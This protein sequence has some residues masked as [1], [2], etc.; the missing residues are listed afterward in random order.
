MSFV[1]T[2]ALL[3]TAQ[4]PIH[5]VSGDEGQPLPGL[6]ASVAGGADLDLDGVPDFL[7]GSPYHSGTPA[8]RVG[9]YSGVDAAPLFALLDSDHPDQDYF[10]F[11]LATIADVNADG[12]PDFLVGAPQLPGA[13]PEPPGFADVRS[14]ADG[15]LL[16]R[17]DGA[18]ADDG[19][20]HAVAGLDD[21]NADL[22]PDFAVGAVQASDLT[23][24]RGYVRIVSGAD[25]ATLLTLQGSGIGDRFGSAVANAGDLNG[26]GL[27]DILVGAPASGSDK[28]AL[29][30]R[31]AASGA[32]LWKKN[33]S[34]P[35]ELYGYAAAAAGD[36]DADGN[37]DVLV[38][39]PGADRVQVL[40]GSTGA[41]ILELSGA[42]GSFFG[43]VVA[44]VGDVDSDGY[45]D[46][47][48]G[49]RAA[50][51]ETGAAWIF[52][53]R[54]ASIVRSFAGGAA[55]DEYGSSAASAADLDLDGYPDALVGAPQGASA[56]PGY[57]EAR[58]GRPAF[59]GDVTTLPMA[60]GGA[61]N[62]SI[63][64]EPA[65]AGH[66]YLVLG[67]QNGTTPGFAFQ[68]FTVPL[69]ID[70]YFTFTLQFPNE[71]PLY[72]SLGILDSE[73]Q[74]TFTF[75]LPAAKFP[76][77]VGS[78]VHHA[79]GELDPALGALVFVSNP[80]GLTFVP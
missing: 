30:A 23:P 74:G 19:F 38:G 76:E 75:A 15:T 67:T 26:D 7:A 31:S 63:D 48:A 42:A 39:V 11:A 47:L 70:N 17:V 12:Q 29:D 50:S 64:R 80:V 61:Q 36:V 5:V 8:G 37:L 40:R 25:G 28:G 16:L 59:A 14:G 35:F 18:A 2:C 49:A 44:G 66:V 3:L 46:V 34:A 57:A 9:V 56:S 69:V 79:F 24:G 20:G 1:I 72:N 68:G 62:I 45:A 73:G 27:S 41:L 4:D 77:L 60:T 58:V 13:A 71:P 55:G 78:S 22:V 21:L 32:T 33:G 10:G 52:S 6:G 54:D 51:G 43:G 65:A 53:G